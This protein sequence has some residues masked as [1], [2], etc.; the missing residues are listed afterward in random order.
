MSQP[1]GS[2]LRDHGLV[3]R[4][5]ESIEKRVLLWR[6]LGYISRSMSSIYTPNMTPE[7]V[8]SVFRDRPAYAPACS[9]WLD[10]IAVWVTGVISQTNISITKEERSRVCEAVLLELIRKAL[11]QITHSEVIGEGVKESVEP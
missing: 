9:Q 6:I 11:V 8:F 3:S 1:G 2:L 7:E 4:L 5:D 10:Q